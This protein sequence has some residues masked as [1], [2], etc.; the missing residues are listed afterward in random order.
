M[1]Q[2]IKIR[3]RNA[4]RN[5]LERIIMRHHKVHVLNTLFDHTF[6]E[7]LVRRLASVMDLDMVE[8]VLPARRCITLG[9]C[10]PAGILF[11]VFWNL[12]SSSC[13]GRSILKQVDYEHEAGYFSMELDLSKTPECGY[14]FYDLN[15]KL[16]EYLLKTRGGGTMLDVGAN[17]GFYSLVASLAFK[18]VYAFEPCSITFTRLEKNIRLSAKN[19][20]HAYPL[21]LSSNSGKTL[22]RVFEAASGNNTIEKSHASE[23]MHNYTDEEINIMTLDEVATKFE[24]EEVDFIKIDVEGHEAEVLRGAQETLRR[25]RPWLFIECHTNEDLKTCAAALP[26]GYAPWD[27]LT[28]RPCSLKDLCNNPN[29]YLDVLFRSSY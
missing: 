28:D 14:Y 29:R 5:F 3:I 12:A 25:W 20:I 17:V 13:Y 18:H 16:T 27:V 4:T 21:G 1:K 9:E 19:H 24:F 7:L 23:V 6:L 10:P 2:R 26:D 8:N 22:L 15:P 11:K